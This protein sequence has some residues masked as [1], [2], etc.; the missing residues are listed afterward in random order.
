MTGRDDL[1]RDVPLTALLAALGVDE[2]DPHCPACGGMLV[3]GGDSAWGYSF[4]CRGPCR[5]ARFGYLW[6]P[7]FAA[8]LWR[9]ETVEAACKRLRAGIADY[10]ARASTPLGRIDALLAGVRR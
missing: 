1:L 5:L 2:Q 8:E 9:V 6:A 10:Q 3:V 7:A 4:S